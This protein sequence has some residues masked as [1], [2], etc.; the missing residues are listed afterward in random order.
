[1]L[2]LKLNRLFYIQGINTV[3]YFDSFEVELFQE[4][5]TIINNKNIATNIFRIHAYDSVMCKYFCIAFINFMLNGKSLTDFANL[6]SAN[7]FLKNDGMIL[8]YFKNA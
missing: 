6:F 3:A 7:K 4:K 5:S 1:M 2:I 8:N